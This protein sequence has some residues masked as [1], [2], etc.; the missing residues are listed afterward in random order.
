VERAAGSMLALIQRVAG[1][2][3]HGNVMAET[4]PADDMVAA[5]KKLILDNPNQ[6][7]LG[8]ARDVTDKFKAKWGSDM[9]F[10]AGYLNAM[11]DYTD[12][13]A[14]SRSV[15]KG[16]AVGRLSEELA[17]IWAAGSEHYDLSR[18]WRKAR[19]AEGHLTG[20]GLMG[21]KKPDDFSPPDTATTASN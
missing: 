15:L 7:G 9:A 11:F 2:G 8:E 5:V 3:K 6:T 17:E 21:A 19:A 12:A 1:S 18:K 4:K 10:G 14:R 20:Y 16:Y 13:P